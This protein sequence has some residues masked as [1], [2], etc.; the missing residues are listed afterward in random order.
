MANQWK[1]TSSLIEWFV[2]IK[3]KKRESFMVFDIG[4]FYPS[5]TER[6][7]MNAIQVA[8]QIAET[9]DYDMSLLN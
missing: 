7:F 9:F 5:I 3:E 4:S 6:L 8:K 2:S 1:D